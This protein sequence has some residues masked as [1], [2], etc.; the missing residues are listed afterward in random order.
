MGVWGFWDLG[1]LFALLS[2]ESGYV[3]LELWVK[4][5]LFKAWDLILGV[6][7]NLCRK[8]QHPNPCKRHE[9]LELKPR[10]PY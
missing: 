1:L 2:A 10:R 4:G 5:F 8:V 3:E 7:Q 6:L 9:A